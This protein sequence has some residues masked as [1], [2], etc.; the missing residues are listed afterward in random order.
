LKWA[1]AEMWR[2]EDEASQ[3]ACEDTG[4]KGQ[5]IGA[6]WKRKDERWR[7]IERV[8]SENADRCT[9]ERINT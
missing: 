1:A 9:N 2:K 8:R 4:Q 7:E 5:R 6:K 3:S